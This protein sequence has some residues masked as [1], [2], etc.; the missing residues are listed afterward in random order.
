ML[1]LRTRQLGLLEGNFIFEEGGGGSPPGGKY[2]DRVERYI[3][4]AKREQMKRGS[5]TSEARCE[6]SFSQT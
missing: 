1:E 3:G 6:S 2:P 5:K 4:M